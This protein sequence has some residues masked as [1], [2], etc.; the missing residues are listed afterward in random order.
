MV[1][2]WIAKLGSRQ[3]SYKSGKSSEMREIKFLGICSLLPPT[4]WL[5]EVPKYVAPWLNSA[6]RCFWFGVQ[7][8][9]KFWIE[10]FWI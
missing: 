4:S 10:N 1:S 9:L 3:E 8:I 5:A 7:N 2:D 6:L